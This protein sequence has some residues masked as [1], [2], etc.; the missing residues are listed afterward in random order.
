MKSLFTNLFRSSKSRDGM[1]EVTPR[2]LLKTLRGDLE[3]SN[4]KDISQVPEE[5]YMT[6]LRMFP[7]TPADK[8]MQLAEKIDDIFL[9]LSNK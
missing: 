2:K 8:R 3:E 9:K 6:V 4:R 7:N 1:Y 5:I